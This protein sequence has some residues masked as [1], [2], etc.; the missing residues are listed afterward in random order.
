[1]DYTIKISSKSINGSFKD[2]C[3]RMNDIDS[4]VSSKHMVNIGCSWYEPGTY[5]GYD[6]HNKIVLSI[7]DDIANEFLIAYKNAIRDR[8]KSLLD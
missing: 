1:M 7:E 6:T 5:P 3:S 8:I 2:L 4:I